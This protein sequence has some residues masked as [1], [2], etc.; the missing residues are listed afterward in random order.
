[1]TLNLNNYITNE[2]KTN[3]KSCTQLERLTYKIFKNGIQF[4][5]KYLQTL[6][7]EKRHLYT[8]LKVVT[9]LMFLF[10]RESTSLLFSIFLKRSQ[11]IY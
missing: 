4:E 10:S 3:V 6:N 7:E 9:G 2:S 1:M 11:K 5:K 8:E